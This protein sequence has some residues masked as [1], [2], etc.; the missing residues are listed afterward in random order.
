MDSWRVSEEL[1]ESGSPRRAAARHGA[2]QRADRARDRQAQTEDQDRYRERDIPALSEGGS[3]R[4]AKILG[5]RVGLGG[6]H[7]APLPNFQT[8]M[9]NLRTL[10]ARLSS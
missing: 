5:H 9:P 8:G 3:S 10:S 4:R 7:A 1:A 2:V 6:A